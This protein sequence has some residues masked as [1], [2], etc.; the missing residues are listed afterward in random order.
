MKTRLLITALLGLL[1]ATPTLAAENNPFGLDLD[2]RPTLYGCSQQQNDKYW[3]HC[4]TVPKLHPEFE[5]YA[6]Q[7]VESVGI[8]FVGAIGKTIRND[9]Y[10]ITTKRRADAIVKQLRPKYGIET[11]KLDFLSPY[12]IWDEP[13][14]WMM[15]VLKEERRYIYS[16][17]ADD[18][19]KPVGEV[20]KIYVAALAAASDAGYV[21][22]DF[23]FKR[24]PLC[25]AIIEKAGRDAF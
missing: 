16:W 10:G 24:E 19:F 3:F 20:A 15:G 12:S 23:H 7:Y 18:G 22:L 13:D 14:E 2:K 17:D 5:E 4:G 25:D 6:V 1:F 11:Q 21:K 9:S 8:C